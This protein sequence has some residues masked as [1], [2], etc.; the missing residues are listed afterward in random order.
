MTA[1]VQI[2]LNMMRQQLLWLER[3]MV[4]LQAQIAQSASSSNPE[5]TFESLRGIWMGVAFDEEDI[6][7]SRL[8]LSEEL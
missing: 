3:E 2:R 7:T 8:K 6:Q 5:R 1:D 4:L